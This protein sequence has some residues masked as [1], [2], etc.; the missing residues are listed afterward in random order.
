MKT[1]YLLLTVALAGVVVYFGSP[2][3]AM[4]RLGYAVEFG[5]PSELSRRIDFDAV[6][7]A[8]KTE[9]ARSTDERLKGDSTST[10]A[11][12]A[13]LGQMLAVAMIS[14]KIDDLVTP[15]SLAAWIERTTT[16]H[17]DVNMAPVRAL[18]TVIRSVH[19]GRFDGANIFKVFV[20][21]NSGERPTI[22]LV[23]SRFGW[24]EWKLSSIQFSSADAPGSL[25]TIPD[26]AS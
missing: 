25:T 20:P 5:S 19:L 14:S 15:N 22:A 24:Y 10:R 1:R 17:D 11:V 7:E 2:Y 12:T 9:L 13:G 4:Y 23:F 18:R 3:W 6:R 26:A 8:T 21:D 16:G